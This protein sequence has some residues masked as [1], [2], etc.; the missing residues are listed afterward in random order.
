MFTS[1]FFFFPQAK[2]ELTWAKKSPLGQQ[3]VICPH[4]LLVKH[5]F[6]F[7]TLDSQF[8]LVLDYYVTI[9]AQTQLIFLFKEGK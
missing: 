9:F 4:T 5:Q 8:P 1:F 3:V 6:T 2:C 7:K